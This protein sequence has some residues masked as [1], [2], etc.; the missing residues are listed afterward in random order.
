[1]G[2]QSCRVEQKKGFYMEESVREILWSGDRP[3]D[4]R[5]LDDPPLDDPPCVGQSHGNRTSG[6][7]LA[8]GDRG[9]TVV[10]VVIA[11]LL[12]SLV[13][14]MAYSTY[15]FGTR[16]FASWRSELNLQ[17]EMHLLVRDLTRK[18]R[19]AKRIEAGSDRLSVTTAPGSTLTYRVEENNLYRNGTPLLGEEIS[20]LD[21]DLELLR[22]GGAPNRRAPQENVSAS[23]L[24]DLPAEVLSNAPA[25]SSSNSALGGTAASTGLPSQVRFRFRIASPEDTLQLGSR[26]HLRNA[27]EWETP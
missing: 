22:T 16:A 1:M 4:N 25:I 24:E 23:S 15:A 5:S 21:A 9:Y 26:V 19:R 18:L 27:V 20:L 12:A 10:E 7:L 6:G 11:M 14:G 3:L 8:L 2:L 13:A 17:N